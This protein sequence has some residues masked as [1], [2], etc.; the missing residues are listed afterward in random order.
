ML[1]TLILKPLPAHKSLPISWSSDRLLSSMFV[2]IPSSGTGSSLAYIP[3][4]PFFSLPST[5]VLAALIPLIELSMNINGLSNRISP[6]KGTSMSSL[7]ARIAKLFVKRIV[8]IVD[9]VTDAW[10]DLTIIVYGWITASVRLTIFLSS[11]W[12]SVPSFRLLFS[13]WVLVW[14]QYTLMITWG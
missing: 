1:L 10:V 4:S 3:S 2:F 8:S 9:L 11:W 7:T 6:I 14:L 12:S 13:S 5:W